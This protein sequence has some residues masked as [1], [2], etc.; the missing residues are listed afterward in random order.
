MGIGGWMGPIICYGASYS[1]GSPCVSERSLEV[2]DLL[3]VVVGFLVEDMVVDGVIVAEIKK[4]KTILKWDSK[5]NRVIWKLW[6]CESFL[7]LD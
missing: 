3:V 4:N 1:S 7:K 6:N 5:A 2:V